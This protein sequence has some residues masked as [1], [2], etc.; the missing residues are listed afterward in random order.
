[1]E[2]KFYTRYQCRIKQN[3]LLYTSDRTFS[4]ILCEMKAIHNARDSAIKG[5]GDAQWRCSLTVLPL[6]P[7]RSTLAISFND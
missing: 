6:F 5:Y 2:V 4:H 7:S 1:M 3:C